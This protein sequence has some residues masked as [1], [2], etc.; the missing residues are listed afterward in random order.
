MKREKKLFMELESVVSAG[1]SGSGDTMGK[2]I[3]QE[4][5]GSRDLF[6]PPVPSRDDNEETWRDRSLESTEKSSYSH[7][8]S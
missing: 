4:S 1:L 3:L 8:Y 6:L 2:P 5:H 7:D